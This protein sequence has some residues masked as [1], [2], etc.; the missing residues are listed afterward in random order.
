MIIY[1]GCWFFLFGA[2]ELTKNANPDKYFYS[3]YSIGYAVR[4]S[5]LLSDG[6]GFGKNMII[7]GAD[8][9]SSLHIDLT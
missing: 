3:G 9:S 8:I 1:S 6:S 2:A 5:S 7:F 4:R